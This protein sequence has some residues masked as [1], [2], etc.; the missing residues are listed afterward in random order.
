MKLPE[1]KNPARYT[2]L[3][4]VDFG[5]FSSTGFT[6]REVA[7]LIESEKYKDCKVYKIH[8]AYP[9]GKLEIKGVR[10]EIFQLES[11]MFFYSYDQMSATKDYKNLLGL[12]VKTAPP[13]QSKI[14]L[15]KYDDGKYV[16]AYIYPAEYEDEVSRW[17]IEGDYK[18]KGPATGG[19]GEV[20]RYYDTKIETIEI[21]QLFAADT[22]QSRTGIEL[23]GNLKVALQR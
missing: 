5:D 20:T 7:Q 14:E 12:A 1:L 19:I 16:T 11:G 6:A 4:I 10:K 3:Y 17:L 9:D 21:H 8:N 23:L 15:S 13:C 18:T 2:G 22:L